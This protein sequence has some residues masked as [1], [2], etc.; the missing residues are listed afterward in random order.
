MAHSC[1]RIDPVSWME[2]VGFLNVAALA[3]DSG[4]AFAPILDSIRR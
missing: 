4:L 2:S 3:K 1:A